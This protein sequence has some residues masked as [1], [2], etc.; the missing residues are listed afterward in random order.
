METEM[1]K[2]PHVSHVVRVSFG[3]KRHFVNAEIRDLVCHV[4]LQ[5]HLTKGSCDFMEGRST[6]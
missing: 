2:R 1:K 4:I 3:V 6:W 5:D